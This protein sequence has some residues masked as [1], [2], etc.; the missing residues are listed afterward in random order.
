M[1]L[2]FDDFFI[3]LFAILKVNFL[4]SERLNKSFIY[5]IMSDL[6]ILETDIKK[7]PIVN[8]NKKRK[9]KFLQFTKKELEIH[10]KFL[11]FK[12]FLNLFCLNEEE[13]IIFL[14]VKFKLLS[15]TS[16]NLAK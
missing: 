11:K 16:L 7:I 13:L 4:R 2:V 10:N 1:E 14:K 8:I 9:E 12:N 15:L 3:V 6:N 5:N